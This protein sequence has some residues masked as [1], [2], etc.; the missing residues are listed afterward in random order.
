MQRDRAQHRHT[1]L[2][3]VHRVLHQ[4]AE[5]DD[6][7]VLDENGGLDGALV[8]RYVGGIGQL[9]ARRGVFLLDL[10]LY[11][12]AFADVRGHLENRADLFTLNRLERT[13]GAADRCGRTGVRAG[14][15]RYLLGDL[16]LRFL[17][18]H[19]DH[20]RRGDDVARAVAAQGLN[21]GGET[22]AGARVVGADG[23]GGAIRDLRGD[24]RARGEAGCGAARIGC[25]GCLAQI[26]ARRRQRG[27]GQ[28]DDAGTGAAGQIDHAVAQVGTAV[29]QPLHAQIG[30]LIDIHL[31]DQGL[32]FDLRPADIELVD[33][34]HQVLHDLGRCGHDEGIG[35]DIRPNRH[36]GIQ[37]A[38]AAAAALRRRRARLR[39]GLRFGGGRGL[40]FEFVGQF[41]SIGVQQVAHLG[42]ACAAGARQIQAEHQ[43]FGLELERFFAADEHAV[44][45]L[46]GD[47]LDRCT[48]GAPGGSLI[49]LI[50]GAHQFGRAG[51]VQRD[52]I[53]RFIAAFIHALDD[54]HDA[55]HVAGA[56][57]DD[58][59]VP[60]RIGRQM[61]LLRDQRPQQGHQ[62]RRAD[63]LH[64]DDLS[65]HLV[66]G[67]AHVARQVDGGQLPGVG[68]RNDLDHL[69]RR[70]RD[71]AV[72]LQ[73]RQEGFVERCRGHRGRRQHGDLGVDARIDDEILAG[74]LADGLNDL[75]QI[76][77]F[78]IG[79]DG[80][81]F[82][83][84]RRRRR[85]QAE[86]H[87][88]EREHAERCRA[89][90]ALRI[91]YSRHHG[92][93]VDGALSNRARV[94]TC[95][96]AI[97]LIIIGGVLRRRRRAAAR[98]R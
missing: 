5:H 81:A 29:E 86:R 43:R 37:V 4:A 3:L 93:P 89:V 91:Q 95:A 41:F 45:A 76:R 64:G 60:G 50:D 51:I 40:S 90:H 35:G 65:D 30:A 62:L 97:R 63:V 82:L 2:A 54:F 34:R 21:Q 25:R 83:R 96:R 44:G 80:R 78:V 58:Q 26:A 68:V 49:Q 38:C 67:G 53:D 66:R 31:D 7:A 8:G 12:V 32:H 59:H 36:A 85:G 13:G 17:V 23:E 57:R 15:Q 56:I 52:D 70:H 18:V 33:H 11:G 16:H 88:Q 87:Q 42:I 48:L 6:A 47:D 84:P 28:V 14:D 46:V 1:I 77:V 39:A 9:G 27:G 74:H 72:D 79:R 19:G 94:S 75:T 69:A 10:E 71:I 55:V 98:R 24:A 92:V 22:L 61:A 73:H 20:P